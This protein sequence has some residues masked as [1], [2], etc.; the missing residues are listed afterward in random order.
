MKRL[1]IAVPLLL[2]VL[3]ILSSLHWYLVKRLALAPGWSPLVET[4]IALLVTAL[5]LSL[6]LQ[7]IGE[8]TLPAPWSRL[9][10][11]PAT[12]WMGLGFLSLPALALSDLLLWGGDALALWDGSA[13][14]LQR[15]R[16]LAVAGLVLGA[17]AVGLRNALRKPELLR[18]ELRL[19]RWPRVLDGYRVVQISDIH[20]GPILGRDFASWLVGRVNALEP[21]LVAITGD[22]VDGRVAT[23]ADEVAPFGG[24]RARDGVYFVTGNHDHY[25][26]AASW[27]DFL[28]GLG[29][30]V[31]RNEGLD[32]EA[33][34][35]RG[36]PDARYCLAGVDDHRGDL[37][38]DGGGEDLERAL[39]GLDAER[40]VLLLAH[41]PSTFKRASK[42]GVDLQLSGH[43]HGGQIWPFVYLVRLAIPF[44]AGLYRIGDSQLYVSR[45]TA[46]WG[47]PLRL[48]APAE[49]TEILLRSE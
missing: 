18:I 44:V 43:T 6:V 19:K 20:I 33:K 15:G 41:D 21:D 25:S 23:L 7:P 29:I 11:W 8:R 16:A 12:L 34:R 47:P 36:A 10:S 49:I 2:V 40:P 17:G 28:R 4:S 48:F 35:G 45:G 3:S 5:G 13:L 39:E 38:F 24:L 30:G 32:V 42:M 46:F 1:A 31:L 14:A 27:T 9:L 26:G 37:G 22:I